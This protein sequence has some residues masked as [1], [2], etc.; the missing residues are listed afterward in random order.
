VSCRCDVSCNSSGAACPS[1]SCP[2]ARGSIMRC[3]RQGSVNCDSS[4]SG[5]D[6]CIDF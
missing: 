1:M 2:I 6:T 3:T 4:P 5:C